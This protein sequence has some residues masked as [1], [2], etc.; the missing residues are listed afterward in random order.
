MHY[1]V[2]KHTEKEGSII[3]RRSIWKD[4]RQL[5]H[6]HEGFSPFAFVD[7]IPHR[8]RIPTIRISVDH[9]EKIRTNEGY[10]DV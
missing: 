5:L 3:G 9:H 7:I 4:I 10:S 6:F 8:V 1:T 2:D